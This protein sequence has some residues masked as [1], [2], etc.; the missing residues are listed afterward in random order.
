MDLFSKQ[1]EFWN[2]TE[3]I[4]NFSQ[5]SILDNLVEI[6]PD[7]LIQLHQD[8]VEGN[9]GKRIIYKTKGIWEESTIIRISKSKCSIG[10][11]LCSGLKKDA[12]AHKNTLNLPKIVDGNR[13]GKN[14]RNIYL[15]K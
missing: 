15:L 3:K 2:N 8:N 9:L 11:A 7:S 5:N 12:T 14:G 1:R 4:Q 10:I 13:V 6:N